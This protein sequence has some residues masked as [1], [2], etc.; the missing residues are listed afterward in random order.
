MTH[1][2]ELEVRA[3]I[4]VQ[5]TEEVAARLI[6]AGFVVQNV[7]HRTM[8]MSFGRIGRIAE[9]EDQGTA[10]TDI[11]C[12]MTNGQAEVVVKIGGV[13]AYDRKE[14]STPIKVEML[15]AF[16]RVVGALNMFHKV[17]SRMTTNYVREHITASIVSSPSGLAYLELEKMSDETHTENDRREL[18]ALAETLGVTLLPDREAFMDLC[19]RLTKRDDWAFHGSE[20]DIER[21]IKEAKETGADLTRS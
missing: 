15:P 7:A 11:R 8:L 2:I 21:F 1:P 18:T 13:H 4:Q 20:A 12:R 14:I 9:D 10:E 3:E 16:A 19:T 5:E 6:Q 17:G